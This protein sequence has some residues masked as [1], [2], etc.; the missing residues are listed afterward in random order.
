MFKRGF[1]KPFYI[2]GHRIHHSCIYYILPTAYA[3]I[4]GLFFLGYI[5][6]QWDSLWIRLADVA[7]LT[8]AA[9][10]VDFIGD[11][12]WPKIRMNVILHHEW[13]Y[14]VIPAFIFAYVVNIVI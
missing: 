9:L 3:M 11:K 4:I 7:T 2:K 8:A 10:A 13:V 1:A 5:Q 14:T 6:L 12:F